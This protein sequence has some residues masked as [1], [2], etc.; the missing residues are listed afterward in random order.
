MRRFSMVHDAT[1]YG[2]SDCKAIAPCLRT[3]GRHLKT[4]DRA[5]AVARHLLDAV[6]ARRR[7][8]IV[9]P[10]RRTFDELERPVRLRAT[11]TSR[12]PVGMSASKIRLDDADLTAPD[13]NERTAARW[14]RR[15]NYFTFCVHGSHLP[16]T[17]APSYGRIGARGVRSRAPLPSGRTRASPTR[18]DVLIC[19]GESRG[20]AWTNFASRRFIFVLLRND[21]QAIVYARRLMAWCSRSSSSNIVSPF[22][23]QCRLLPSQ[24]PEHL[25]RFRIAARAFAG[26]EI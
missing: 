21:S 24:P 9:A 3:R 6:A 11:A 25:P 1:D 5:A 2:R 15:L 16:I 23:L 13:T 8:R 17:R 7:R 12:A 14:T 22:S 18:G 19:S 20:E 4:R 10:T 26:G